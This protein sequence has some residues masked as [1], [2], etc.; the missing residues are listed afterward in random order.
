MD[1]SALECQPVKRGAEYSGE[2]GQQYIAG[3]CGCWASPAHSGVPGLPPRGWDGT[4]ATLVLGM[5]THLLE[6]RKGDSRSELHSGC[7]ET[8]I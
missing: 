3:P 4:S 7:P 8:T 2:G 6:I 1:T 5:S